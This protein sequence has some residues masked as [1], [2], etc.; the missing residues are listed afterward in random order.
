MSISHRIMK[1]GSPMRGTYGLHAK[2][3]I[4]VAQAT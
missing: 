4:H 3:I 2:I 1:I